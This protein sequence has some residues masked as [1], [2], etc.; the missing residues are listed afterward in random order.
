MWLPIYK[1]CPRCGKRIPVE[2]VCDCRKTRHREY[3]V[4]RT[5]AKEQ[6]F[7][8]S[9]DWNK[10]KTAAIWQCCGIDLYSLYTTGKVETGQTVHHII[11]LKDNWEQRLDLGNLIYL[12][13]ENH[14]CIHK[15]MKESNEEKE[16]I[17]D[18][19]FELKKQFSQEFSQGRG[20]SKM[21]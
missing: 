9:E 8:W 11:P 1:R 21:F 13:E 20:W 7:Y 2:Q 12:T 14:Q 10:A 3:N 15:K 5:D 6:K 17:I 4:V 18:F 19:L 16:K